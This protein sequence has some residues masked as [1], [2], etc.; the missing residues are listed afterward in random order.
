MNGRI[1]DLFLRLKLIEPA[2]IR[3]WHVTYMTPN[4]VSANPTKETVMKTTL[5]AIFASAMLLASASGAFAASFLQASSTEEQLAT[6]TK[7]KA[8]TMN[9]TDAAD[10]ITNKNGVATVDAD[11]AYFIMAAAQVGGKAKGSVRLW[12]RVNGK[13]VDNS[14]TEQT[15]SAPSFTAVL[16]SQ[17]VAMLKKGDK[18]EMVYSGSA[19]GL[20]LIVKKPAGE[21]VVPSIIFSAFKV[22]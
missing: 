5:A 7:P 6:N 4:A 12:I 3:R 17:G 15:I 22:N 8:V 19:P 13:D 14:N 20:G 21:P 18:I 9:T 11:G 16:V 10:G 2:S 1:A